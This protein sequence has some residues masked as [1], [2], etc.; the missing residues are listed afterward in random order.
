MKP[1]LPLWILSF[2]VNFQFFFEVDPG[3]PIG[4]DQEGTIGRCF[5]VEPLRIRYSGG[6]RFELMIL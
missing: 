1:S 5:L 3:V 4:R 6:H 2:F